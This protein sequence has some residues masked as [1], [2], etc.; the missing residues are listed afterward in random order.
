MTYKKIYWCFLFWALYE[1]L[2]CKGYPN[3]DYFQLLWI[4]MLVFS[5]G[6]LVNE[7]FKEDKNE[8]NS[9]SNFR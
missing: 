8:Q 1:L 3:V 9:E 4:A 5:L 6:K 2:F 7:Y